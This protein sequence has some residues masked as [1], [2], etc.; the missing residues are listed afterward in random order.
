MFSL[1][2]RRLRGDIV[3]LPI[4]EDYYKQ[5]SDQGRAAAMCLIFSQAKS[6]GGIFL[7][8]LALRPKDTGR[9]T[10]TEIVKS[11]S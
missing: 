3:S 9:D 1:E 11:L 7:K 5:D 8:K 4:Y 6:W 2:E 10:L